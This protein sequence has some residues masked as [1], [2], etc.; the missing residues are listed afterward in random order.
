MFVDIAM[1]VENQ[2]AMI[3]RIENN[4]DQSVGFVERAVADT[5]KAVKYQSEARRVRRSVVDGALAAPHAV[6]QALLR[7]RL[8]G[9]GHAPDGEHGFGVHAAPDGQPD[10]LKV[11]PVQVAAPQRLREGTR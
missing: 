1:L 11:P 2:G 6:P 7:H 8:A 9:G 10:H 5:K 4:M 3:D